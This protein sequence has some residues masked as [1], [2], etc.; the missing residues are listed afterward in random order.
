[1]A[2]LADLEARFDAQLP[3][4]RLRGPAPAALIRAGREWSS[5]VVDSATAAGMATLRASNLEAGLAIAPRPVFICGVHRSG[6]TLVRDL[7]DGHP[8]ISV[9]PSEG[10][11]FT[12]IAPALANRP[13][14]TWFEFVAAEWVRRL[15][16][17][18]N[19]PPY[20][21]LGRTTAEDSP[22]VQFARTLASWWR[23]IDARFGTTHL[24]WPL[25]AVALAWAHASGQLPKRT[26]SRWA[27]K[28]PANERFLDQLTREFPEA[29][30]VHVVRHP[31]AVLASRKRLE[32]DATGRFGQFQRALDDL[33]A[34][35]RLAAEGQN[36]QLGYCRIRYEDVIA[37]PTSET[38]RLVAA[39][40]VPWVP[41]MLTP[42]VAGRPAS[43]NTASGARE[44][45]G[46]ILPAAERPNVLTSG[47]RTRIVDALGDL[48][49]RLGY[50]LS[51]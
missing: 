12:N 32:V 3:P 35:F 27:E 24:S 11:H 22:Y 47:E 21:L 23:E 16:N 26:L 30:I 49:C 39:A 19:R 7:L 4:D 41:E 33:L 8:A 42:S 45:R 13:R 18:I 25:V 14:A 6:T 50:D 5:L 46:L 48:A 31:F 17:P 40:G 34:S 51:E 28:T 44:E 20:W 37:N 43:T 15:A 10:A 38:T 2:T 1:V 9:L 36:D 29:V